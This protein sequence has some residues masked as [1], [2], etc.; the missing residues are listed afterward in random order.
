M[1]YSQAGNSYSV[2]DLAKVM[3]QDS[4]NTATNMLMST[5]GSMNDINAALKSWGIK[6]M[7]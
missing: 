3:I 6:Q 1:Q 5:L 7:K 2:R 4:D